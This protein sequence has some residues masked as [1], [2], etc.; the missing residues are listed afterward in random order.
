[1]RSIFC[2]I[3]I[4]VATIAAA[5]SKS[6][7]DSMRQYFSD[8]VAKHQV[9]T[10]EDKKLMQFYNPERKYRVVADFEPIQNAP[11]FNINTSSGKTRPFRQFGKISFK[12]DGKAQVLYLYQEQRFL[13]N[14]K[15]WDHLF[16]PFMDAT[17]GKETYETGRYIDLTMNDINNKKVVIDFNKAYNP[18][19][20]YVSDKYSCPIPPKE[21]HLKVA[22]KAGEKKYV[23]A[24]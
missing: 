7:N 18:Y 12:I 6:Y 15:Y 5:Q 16:L 9:V 19:C 3:M 13:Q 23:K 11:W 17:N 2:L 10:G 21:N 22:I 20:A 1:M 14:P 24:H 8:Y 4:F